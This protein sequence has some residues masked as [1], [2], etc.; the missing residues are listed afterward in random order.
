MGIIG[1][2]TVRYTAYLSVTVFD[3]S[4]ILKHIVGIAVLDKNKLSTL[5]CDGNGEV[6]VFD[7]SWILK[8]EVGLIAL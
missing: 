8:K 3:A 2:Y 4:A 6:N 7:A 1:I 5:D